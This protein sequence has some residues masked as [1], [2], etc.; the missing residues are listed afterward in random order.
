M[1]DII[2]LLPDAIANQ[3]AAGEVVQRPS[4]VVKELIEN[5]I[6]S[7]A[8]RIRL[9]LKVAGKQLIQVID[10]GCGMSMTDARMS[11]AR[12]ATSKI[13]K[14]EDLFAIQTLGFRGEALAS[15]A[16]VAQVDL[17]TRPHDAEVGTH[18]EIMGSEV[19]KQEACETQPGTDLSVR[20]LFYNIPA[21]RKFLK[22]DTVELRHILDEFQR[23]ALAHPKIHFE[24]YHN[25]NEM[26]HLPPDN[27]RKRIVG[28][29]GKVYNDRLVPVEEDTDI[30]KIIG[31]VGKP[32][33]AKRRRG[34]QFLMV[35]GRFIKSAYLSHAISSAYQNI[36]PEG[37]H[38]FYLLFLSMDTSR[39]DVNVHP[40]KQE[41]KFE[42]EKIIY[43]VIKAAVRHA[44][45]QFNIT[46]T[47]DFEQDPM[48][49]QMGDLTP[50]VQKHKVIIPS[51]FSADRG[52]P[53]WEDL[54]EGL[55]K[56]GGETYAVSEESQTLV[57]A[58]RKAPY[59][60]HQ[61]Y[62]VSQIKSGFIL[63]DQYRAHQQIIFES[64]L[65]NLQGQPAQ[66]QKLLFPKSLEFPPNESAILQNHLGQLQQMGFD[67]EPFGKG[68][69]VLHGI[70]AH[71]T[72]LADVDDIV[73]TLLEQI[74][75]NR[76]L[77]IAEEQ[78][79]A[80]MLA[81]KSAQKRG[82]SLTIEEMHAL[83]DQLFACESPFFGPTGL[84]IILS[85]SL[86]EI[87]D[88]MNS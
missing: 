78:R 15:I 50:M 12:H 72:G 11:F 5:S 36:L 54:Y 49:S 55:E 59:Q 61:T 62:I 18:I 58:E 86:D 52:D 88:K 81:R 20:N 68:S 65:Q 2:Q 44:L 53:A 27:L 14:A 26:Y 79:L 85:F 56:P 16:A 22:S 34:E 9:V 82:V 32:E 24:V 23:I 35:N 71:L 76:D 48:L 41:I 46:P 21:R 57:D 17:K 38:P 1:V 42:D 70:P 30:C 77:E 37:S 4:S 25:G 87:K 64:F 13:S 83:I 29:F 80:W 3:I 8:T 69:F 28:I 7:G 67:L 66:I 40:T 74:G 84:R 19:V 45:N 47:L 51:K 60:I 10:N 73:P 31:F 43:N 63:I 33:A 39:I 75:S 6:D